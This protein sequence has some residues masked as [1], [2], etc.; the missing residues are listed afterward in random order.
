MYRLVL[1]IDHGGVL[2][3]PASAGLDAAQGSA[4]RSGQ[5]EH[6]SRRAISSPVTQ[7]NRGSWKTAFIL[8]DFRG[9][10]TGLAVLALLNSGVPVKDPVVKDGLTFLR[11]L[12]SDRT[13]VRALQTM[14]L[15]EA[16]QSDD[17]ELI[18]N[19]VDWLLSA[20]VYDDKN[21]LLGWTY[22]RNTPGQERQF[23]FAV[24]HARL[25]GRADVFVGTDR[26]ETQGPARRRRLEANSRF[27]PAH[28]IEGSARQGELE[29]LASPESVRLRRLDH[30]DPG[31]DLRPAHFGHGTQRRP[32]DAASR[33]HGDQLRRLQRHQRHP[34]RPPMARRS[35]VRSHPSTIRWSSIISPT[36][37]RSRTTSNANTSRTRSATAS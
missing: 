29:L 15:A 6:K 17:A 36:T 10:E 37:R 18:K 35:T 5:E 4:R 25:V 13:Y 8:L 1:I 26:R 16:G 7:Q 22:K 27:L 32:G 34:G 9:G 31:R 28:P 23:Q 30:H 3:P 14:A 33:R 20:R 21:R 12:E 2:C 24:R 11:G 19:H